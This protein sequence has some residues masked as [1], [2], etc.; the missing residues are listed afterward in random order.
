[1]KRCSTAVEVSTK[2]LRRR[3][4]CGENAVLDKSTEEERN[5]NFSLS[6]GGG[7]GRR[8]EASGGCSLHRHDPLLRG[9]SLCTHRDLPPPTSPILQEFLDSTLRVRSRF[10][11]GVNRCVRSDTSCKFPSTIS[12]LFMIMSIRDTCSMKCIAEN[13]ENLYLARRIW[14]QRRSYSELTIILLSLSLKIH[15]FCLP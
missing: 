1:M 9:Y 15:T 14:H 8:V 12:L 5:R 3:K 2:H 13:L 10:D 6:Y 4:A 7:S 11:S